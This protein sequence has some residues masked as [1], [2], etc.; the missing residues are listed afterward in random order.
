MPRVRP[1]RGGQEGGSWSGRGSAH[2]RSERIPVW[3]RHRE[4]DRAYSVEKRDQNRWVGEK[5]YKRFVKKK[6]EGKAPLEACLGLWDV[7]LDAV[8]ALRGRILAEGGCPLGS[9]EPPPGFL[10]L[11]VRQVQGLFSRDRK[12]SFGGLLWYWRG[13]LSFFLKSITSQNWG[14]QRGLVPVRE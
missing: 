4:H 7:D 13:D 3:L 8:C 11:S 6:R 12:F 5:L 9:H 2:G 10:T 14:H 1:W